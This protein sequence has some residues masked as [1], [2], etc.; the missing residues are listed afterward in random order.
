MTTA[1][2]KNSVH[3]ITVFGLP[4]FIQPF[5][6]VFGAKKEIVVEAGGSTAKGDTL[7]SRRHPK[8]RS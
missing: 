7:S 1:R 5:Q 8:L 2:R 3:R 4:V 6:V